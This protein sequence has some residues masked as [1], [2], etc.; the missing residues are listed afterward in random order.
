M[1]KYVAARVGSIVPVLLG[2]SLAAF[3]LIKLVPG[4]PAE[5][6]AG[7]EAT[8]EQV[9]A[10][11]TALGLDQPLHVQYLKWLGGVLHGDLGYSYAERGAVLPLLLVRF[12]NTLIL[13]VAAAAIALTAGVL[14]GVISATRQ[15]SVF[16]RLA[17][18]LVLLGNSMPSFWLGLVLIFLFA[19]HFRLFPVAG[20]YSVRGDGGPLDLVHHLVLPALTLGIVSM[21]SI[22]R[23]TRSS[24]LEVIHQDYIR[25]ARAKGLTEALVVRRHALKNALIP[26]LT[27]FGIQV[28]FLLGGTV[29]V[30]T[31]FAWPGVGLLMYQA[32]SK[33]DMIV[34]QGGVLFL[35]TIFVCVNLAVDLLYGCLDPRIHYE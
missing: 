8:G 12:K 3:L 16:D 11:R 27:V 20:M 28:G 26:V 14:V 17:M 33:R 22:A 1:W 29:L 2:V 32:I 18:L 35:A 6:L 24:M 34:V 19:Y 15:Y 4:D 25:T 7:V 30:E 5:A 9:A 23:M 10:I 21:A 13:A 31:V